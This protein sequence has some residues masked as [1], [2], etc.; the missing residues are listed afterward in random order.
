M[1]KRDSPFSSFTS[2][3]KKN[4]EKGLSLFVIFSFMD[5]SPCRAVRA[6]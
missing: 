2:W 6:A 1:T 5:F 4:D 3:D